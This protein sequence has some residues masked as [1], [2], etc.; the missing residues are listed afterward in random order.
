MSG[1]SNSLMVQISE[2]QRNIKQ[3][4]FGKF[5]RI[6]QV[7]MLLDRNNVRSFCFALVMLIRSLSFFLICTLHF[8]SD[9]S[10][11]NFVG[12]AV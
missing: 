3:Q 6:C 2:Q 7:I 11:L 1:R 12:F 4:C 8:L 9:L 10:L 5:I